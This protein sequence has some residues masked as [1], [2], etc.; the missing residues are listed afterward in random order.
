MSVINLFVVSGNV[1]RDAVDA[2][3][4]GGVPIVRFSIAQN[5]Y[6]KNDSGGYDESVQYVEL[7]AAGNAAERISKMS[8]LKGEHVTATGSIKVV[9][10]KG[11]DGKTSTSMY[12]N[13]DNVDRSARRSAPQGQAP[14]QADRD[15]Y[16]TEDA[17]F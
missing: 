15:D 1:T 16:D 8:I 5:T 9:Q 7:S 17:P 12:L 14:A 10:T 3:T 13:V 6:R 2:F 11:Q 4:P